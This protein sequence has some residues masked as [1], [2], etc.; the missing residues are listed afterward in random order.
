MNANKLHSEIRNTIRFLPRIPWHIKPLFILSRFLYN[1]GAHTSLEKGVKNHKVK[2]SG[3]ELSIFTPENN[4]P[5]CAVLWC[6]GGGHWAGNPSHL[7]NL[8]SIAVRELDAMVIAPKYRLAPKHPFPADL[9][10]CF[11][12]WTWLVQNADVKG[13]SLDKLAIAGHSS[14]GGLAAALAQ[15]ILDEGGIQPQAQCLFYPMIDDRTAVNFSLHKV[16]HFIWN[17]KVNQICWDT[18]LT[19]NK[20]GAV[21]LPKY[22]A[23]ARRKN[24]QKLPPTWIGQCEL[25]L[26]YEENKAYAER[27]KEAGVDCEVYLQKGVPHA[28]EV[29]AP[30]AKIS[31]QLNATAIR[32]LGRKLLFKN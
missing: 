7:N 19:P 8:A 25:D 10:D 15:R 32:F 6:H 9:E 30:K 21:T 4:T 11:L 22:A 14:G 27:L 31:K 12:G 28:F 17:N 20:A 18:Y 16:N 13:I 26:F 2:Y 1:I 24:L 23:A 29:L 3:V 5:K